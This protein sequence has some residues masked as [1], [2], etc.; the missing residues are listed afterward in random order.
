MPSQ[1][2]TE[3][4]LA[5]FAKEGGDARKT[6]DT[7]FIRFPIVYKWQNLR[8]NLKTIDLT[9]V[10]WTG[11]AIAIE[12]KQ[13]IISDTSQ[14]WNWSRI[15]ERQVDLLNIHMERDA[16]AYLWLGFVRDDRQRSPIAQ[17]LIPWRT[18]RLIQSTLKKPNGTLWKSI[19]VD[20][21][22]QYYGFYEMKAYPYKR[23]F[24]WDYQFFTRYEVQEAVRYHY[25]DEQPRVLDFE[26]S[27]PTP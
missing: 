1:N 24:G 22:R 21:L 8:G 27:Y 2:K 11:R 4:R 14:R 19:S 17:F 20:D 5:Y 3:Q 7:N 13:T 16:H 18:C 9:G 25:T 6:Y 10:T 26:R 12:S 15:N 23:S